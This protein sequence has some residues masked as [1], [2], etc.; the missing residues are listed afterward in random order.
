MKK[1]LFTLVL[2]EDI[3]T[4]VE[5]AKYELDG[6]MVLM[7][8]IIENKDNK[9]STEV[10]SQFIKEYQF[11]NVEYQIS[12]CEV[13]KLYVPEQ[14][15]SPSYVMSIDFSTCRLLI[16]EKEAGCNHV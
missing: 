10:Y 14:F 6:Y 4:I 8:S 7:K 12:L 2:P 5:R 9:F 15:I 13:R 1:V 16:T 11:A 3:S